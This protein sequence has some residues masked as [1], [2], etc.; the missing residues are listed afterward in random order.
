MPFFICECECVCGICSR[1]NCGC[2]CHDI[3]ADIHTMRNFCTAHKLASESHIK[4]LSRNG[5]FRLLASMDNPKK[6]LKQL[7]RYS[8]PTTRKEV[9]K[10][11]PRSKPK[12]KPKKQKKACVGDV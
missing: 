9:K 5:I 6:D 11:K 1:K 8:K 10:S 4:Q 12:S 2:E 3:N 7:K